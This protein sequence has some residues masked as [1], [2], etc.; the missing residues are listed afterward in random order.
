MKGR[1]APV[2]GKKISQKSRKKMRNGVKNEKKK[3]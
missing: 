1:K 2:N 3:K